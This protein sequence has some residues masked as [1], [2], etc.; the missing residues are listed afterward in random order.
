[1][2][3]EKCS[4]DLDLMFWIAESQAQPKSV[5]SYGG[6]A[7]FPPRDTFLWCDDCELAECPF[8]Y[9]PPGSLKTVD[10]KACMDDVFLAWGMRLPFGRGCY[11]P[12]DSMHRVR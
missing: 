12:S 10:G 3:N 5:Y 4:H 2:L 8:R 1:M 9:V 11:G 7:F 6:Q